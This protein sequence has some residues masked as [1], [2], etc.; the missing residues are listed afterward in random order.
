MSAL[1][2]VFPA[3]SLTPGAKRAQDQMPGGGEPGHVQ[4]NLGE[5]NRGGDW[6]SKMSEATTDHLMQASSRS[7]SNRLFSAVRALT[8]SMR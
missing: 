1:P 6:A 4:T 5:D 3:D 7:F 2:F 8:R